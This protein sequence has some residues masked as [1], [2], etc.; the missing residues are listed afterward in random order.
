MK[1]KQRTKLLQE[2]EFVAEVPVELIETKDD[3]SPCLSVDDAQR[4]DEVRAAL[5]RGDLESAARVARI[6]RLIPVK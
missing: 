1:K 2:G 5:R 4:L 6:F 3:W